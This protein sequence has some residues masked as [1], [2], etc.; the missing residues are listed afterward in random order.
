MSPAGLFHSPKSDVGEM[1]SGGALRTCECSQARPI[2]FFNRLSWPGPDTPPLLMRLFYRIWG[3]P[4]GT[5]FML[6][7]SLWNSVHWCL[8]MPASRHQVLFHGPAS[9]AHVHEAA[10]WSKAGLELGQGSGTLGK[11]LKQLKQLMSSWFLHWRVNSVNATIFF[12]L[13]KFCS[14]A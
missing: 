10:A 4:M 13:S 7:K 1:V 3:V 8:H 14:R 5:P 11:E 2:W 9:T 6:D 12:S